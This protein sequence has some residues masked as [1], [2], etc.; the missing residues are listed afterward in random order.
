MGDAFGKGSSC[1]EAASQG[2]CNKGKIR[3][4]CCAMCKCADKMGNTKNGGGATIEI[5]DKGQC[6]AYNPHSADEN[7]FD[8]SLK[9]MEEAFGPAA[10]C[11]HA[12]AMGQ[13]NAGKKIKRMCCASCGG[14]RPDAAKM[15]GGSHDIRQGGNGDRSEDDTGGHLTE[16][17]AV[18]VAA[19]KEL[20]EW[21]KPKSGCKD[22]VAKDFTDW[23]HTTKMTE[24]EKSIG[25]TKD[26]KSCPHAMFQGGCKEAEIKSH[27]C[28][29]CTADDGAV[30]IDK[31]A[32][33]VATNLGLTG[34]SCGTL[35]QAGRCD[36]AAVKKN[37]CARCRKQELYPVC[38]DVT[39]AEL[40]KL[41][42]KPGNDEGEGGCA[43][44]AALGKC[45]KNSDVHKACCETCT[46]HR[47]IT[48]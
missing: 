26:A 44:A 39:E 18:K 6:K 47:D 24:L 20:K 27:C 3:G 38:K 31:S 7:C 43:H 37:C 45:E 21:Q 23:W 42:G 25:L 4:M 28:S 46:L 13:C 32:S 17:P 15:N 35:A 29:S 33:E 48:Q 19:P 5:N 41:I 2:H 22:L 1:Q 34:V 10:S 9:V 16:P 11:G 14:L 12:V 8:S 40:K 36:H 30:C